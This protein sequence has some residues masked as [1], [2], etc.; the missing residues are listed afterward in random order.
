VTDDKPNQ[1][2]RGS[3]QLTFKVL[4]ARH[5]RLALLVRN[6]TDS[7]TDNAELFEVKLAKQ[8]I[9]KIVQALRE[10][11]ELIPDK[12]MQIVARALLQDWQDLAQ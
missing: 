3:L 11:V 9:S 7:S 4:R 2:S 8:D 12:G 6:I 5:A 10:E 1:F